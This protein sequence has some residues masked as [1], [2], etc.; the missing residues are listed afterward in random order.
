MGGGAF[1]VTPFGLGL[2]GRGSPVQVQPESRRRLLL[3]LCCFSAG[4]G[5]V[6]LVAALSRPVE[7]DAT[8]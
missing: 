1:G 2:G 3:E 7:N 6:A 5:L 4:L 8:L